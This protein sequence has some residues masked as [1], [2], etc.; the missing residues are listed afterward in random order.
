[1]GHLIDDLLQL[2]RVTRSEMHRIDVDLSSLANTIASRLLE[3]YPERKIEI[4]IQPGLIA[5]GDPV[6]IEVLL[7]NLLDNACKF[8]RKQQTAKIEFGQTEPDPEH[9]WFVRDNGVGF[10]M[11]YSEK[12][13]T[14]FQRMHKQSEFP[15][16]G[17]GLATVQRI[18]HRHG[19]RIWADAKPFQGAT[20]YFTLSPKK[21]EE[22]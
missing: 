13:F 18:V 6:M 3:T 17:I 11:T 5:T 12:L 19:G 2:S 7:T 22:P 16:T 21:H 4:L 8:T 1:M 15:G 14:A 10:D 9:P 20:F